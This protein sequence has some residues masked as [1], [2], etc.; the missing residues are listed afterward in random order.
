VSEEK[1]DLLVLITEII[2]DLFGKS[3][4]IFNEK[5]GND[6]FGM[7]AGATMADSMKE[8]MLMEIDN[9]ISASVIAELSEALKISIYG[10][11]PK[12]EKM[13]G[14][15]L[16]EYVSAEVESGDPTSVILTNTTFHFGH[17]Q[18][19]HPQF[20]WKLSTKIFEV[21]PAEQLA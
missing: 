11:V 17:S 4:L 13:E 18:E 15:K 8:A 14:N 16:Q 10:D 9:I 7:V 21:V 12:L 1:G 3:Y 19:I 2:G 5:E 6:V 20:I